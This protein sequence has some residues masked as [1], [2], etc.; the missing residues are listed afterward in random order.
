MLNL[1]LHHKCLCAT[2]VHLG[3]CLFD[4]LNMKEAYIEGKCVAFI[5]M[6]YYQSANEMRFSILN[7]GFFLTTLRVVP[8]KTK[9]VMWV[10]PPCTFIKV[11]LL[12]SFR[13]LQ[14]YLEISTKM[15]QVLT[16]VL[17][18]FSFFLLSTISSGNNS[19]ASVISVLGNPSLDDVDVAGLDVTVLSDITDVDLCVGRLR[20]GDGTLLLDDWV[21]GGGS[22]TL[23]LTD[24]LIW[25]RDLAV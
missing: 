23:T 14:F 18:C 25:W 2:S 19:T 7:S 6:C 10:I 20:V 22:S 9:S 5:L 8:K 21:V 3:Q 24:E 17:R 16:C 1:F 12:F 11:D 13:S 15:K 4:Q